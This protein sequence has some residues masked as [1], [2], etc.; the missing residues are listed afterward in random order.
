MVVRERLLRLDNVAREAATSVDPQ[1]DFYLADTKDSFMDSDSLP[2]TDDEPGQDSPPYQPQRAIGNEPTGPKRAE[3]TPRKHRGV[4]VIIIVVVVALL[5]TAAFF[6][7][8]KLDDS[9][10]PGVA[11]TPVAAVQDYLEALSRGDATT[12]LLYSAA[13]P[14]DGTFLT[15]AF[16]TTTM[17]ASPL[18]DI[19][20]PDGQSAKS[21]ATIQATYTLGGNTVNASFT[22]QKYGRKWLL[23]GGF[24]TLNISSLTNKNVPLTM[25]GTA[26]DAST[27][28][29][30]L[31]PG[32]Y[33]FT[34]ANPM[35]DVTNGTFTID[36]P[37]SNPTFNQIGFA[38][39]ADGTSRIQ[40]AAQAKLTDC[41]AQKNL[42][43][44]GC[45]FGASSTQDVD[46]ATIAW[47]L[48]PA[49][50]DITTIQ[51]QLD[52]SS[53]TSAVATTDITVSLAANTPG[54]RSLL[55]ATSTI[56][57]VRADFTDPDNIVVTF[58]GQ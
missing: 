11:R 27:T 44:D 42:Q 10:Q 4:V 6:L 52:G 47:S 5:A 29:V 16:L 49:T 15:N 8:R 33:S 17:S 9:G 23:D 48:N 32:V 38:L 36:Y 58:G 25:N 50:Q 30:Q 13:Q 12:A 34:S 21:P 40:A 51:P 35:L 53:L 55:R 22:V 14:S 20:V 46:P 24:L 31:F 39:S 18:S 54:Q 7:V 2:F 28:K 41:L 3:P 45:G 57:G 19:T 1:D 26:V 43:P 37:E 56:T